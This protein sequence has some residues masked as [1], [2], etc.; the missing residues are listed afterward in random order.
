MSATV[1]DSFIEHYAEEREKYESIREYAEKRLKASLRD[2]GIMEI[3]NSRVKNPERLKEKLYLRKNEKDYASY[4]DI[5]NDIVD[6]IGIRVALYFPND[7]PKVESIIKQLFKIEKTKHFPAEQRDYIE[8]TRRF[9]GYCAT[10]YRVYLKDDKNLP[11]GYD[12]IRIEIQVASLLMHAWAEVEHDLAYK[13]KKGLVSYDEFESL[14]EINGLVIA[15]EIS[16]QR[17]KRITELRTKTESKPFTNHY[18]LASFIFDC[19][20][21]KYPGDVVLGDVE[22]LFQVL[23]AVNRLTPTK[24][25]NDLQSVDY[26]DSTPLAQQIIDKYADT[27]IKVSNIVLDAKDNK[28][29]GYGLRKSEDQIVGEFLRNWISLEKTIETEMKGSQYTEPSQSTYALFRFLKDQ[30]ILSEDSLHVYQDL[31][32]IRN[33]LVHSVEPHD[34]QLLQ[35]CIKEIRQLQDEIKRPQ[36]QNE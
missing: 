28:I 6:F 27:N 12:D 2:A 24:I 30:K 33:E 18:V 35:N 13:Q 9:A 17:L 20:E 19:V 23:K 32:R 15:G 31:R 25:K 34:K 21:D 29:G 10:H 16:L 3:T 26:G 1:I 7:Q 5:T 14:D 36:K 8:Y 22:T 11:A 4:N